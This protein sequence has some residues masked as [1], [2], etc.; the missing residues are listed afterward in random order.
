MSSSNA[1]KSI[2]ISTSL[3]YLQV[4]VSKIRMA[5]KNK[6]FQEEQKKIQQERIEIV[7]REIEKQEEMIRR[8]TYLCQLFPK[9]YKKR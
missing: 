5:K 3:S 2:K 4:K 1:L 7:K 6:I 8:I 9:N